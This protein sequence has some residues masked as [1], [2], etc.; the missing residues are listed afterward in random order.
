MRSGI[1]AMPSAGLLTMALVGATAL[2]GCDRTSASDRPNAAS[3]ASATGR[4]EVNLSP[5]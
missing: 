1:G 3:V 4:V 2:V 5:T